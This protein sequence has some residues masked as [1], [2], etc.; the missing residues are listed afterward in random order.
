MPSRPDATFETDGELHTFTAL[1]PEDP[2]AGSLRLVAMPERRLNAI[3][4]GL[5]AVIAL[6]FVRT[7][8]LVK[9]FAFTLLVIALVLAGVFLP[10]F[11]AEVMNGAL[12]AAVGSVF[13]VWLVAM[14]VPRR[15]G[16]SPA[17][18]ESVLISGAELREMGELEA[19]DLP[20]PS[21]PPADDSADGLEGESGGPRH[22]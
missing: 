18:R 4:F 20:R 11:A 2:P 21:P 8:P 1:Q 16:E 7:P 15:R 6:V 19:K 17:A 3:L 14:A 5:L 22:A 9:L 10:I 12:L 13:L